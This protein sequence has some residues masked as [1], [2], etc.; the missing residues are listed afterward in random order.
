M[1]LRRPGQPLQVPGMLMEA[2]IEVVVALDEL[3]EVVDVVFSFLLARSR[4]AALGMQVVMV[5]EE[6]SYSVTGVA[7]TKTVVVV[8]GMM[9]VMGEVAL[10]VE[11][12]VTVEIP[13]KEE[14]NGEADG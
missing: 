9:V 4:L 14:Q 8:V 6:T 5:V 1:F 13:R 2:G 10:T 3:D 11:V 12:V 7:A